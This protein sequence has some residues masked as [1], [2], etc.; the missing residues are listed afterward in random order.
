MKVPKIDVDQ[1]VEEIVENA[2]DDRER[3]IA[4]AEGLRKFAEKGGAESEGTGEGMDPEVAL[5][6]S[7]QI[8]KISDSLTKINQQLVS[9]VQ[10]DSKK[11]EGD[12]AGD[13]RLSKKDKEAV[14][15]ELESK[16]GLDA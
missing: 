6:L 16:R 15:E 11:K 9:L 2:R 7:E 3:L 5:A 1:L 13:G 14:Y 12:V 8:A 4:C 10:I